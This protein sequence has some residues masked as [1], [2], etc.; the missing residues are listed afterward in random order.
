MVFSNKAI[1]RLLKITGCIVL[2]S[3]CSFAQEKE[4]IWEN[5]LEPT[6]P[7]TVSI[8]G[9]N[10]GLIQ[11]QIDDIEVKDA[12]SFLMSTAHGIVEFNGI[13]FKEIFKNKK[14]RDATFKKLLFCKKRT[15]LFAIDHANSLYE[16]FPSFQAIHLNSENVF[17]ATL[18]GDSLISVCESGNIY[19]TNI[20]TKKIS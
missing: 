14:Y 11:N 16:V 3:C 4:V 13:N 17:A 5:S 10:Q 20:L 19:V 18:N 6:I 7:F 2:F 8:Y 1:T 12:N 9:T 15:S